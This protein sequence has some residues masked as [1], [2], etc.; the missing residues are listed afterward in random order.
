MK[1]LLYLAW[2]SSKTKT[3]YKIAIC[4]IKFQS[5]LIDQIAGKSS[6]KMQQ[7]LTHSN[8]AM[9][10]PWEQYSCCH[11]R[12]F[13]FTVCWEPLQSKTKTLYSSLLH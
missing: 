6:I 3:V 11:R 2:Q 12:S 10:F 5:V 1:R 9:I 7:N 8:P 4:R 13:Q